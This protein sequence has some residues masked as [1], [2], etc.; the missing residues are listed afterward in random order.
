MSVVLFKLAGVNRSGV[1]CAR[2][3]QVEI[4]STLPLGPGVTGEYE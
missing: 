3:C 4:K 1:D 2:Y